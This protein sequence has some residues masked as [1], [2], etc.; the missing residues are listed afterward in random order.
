MTARRGWSL[1]EHLALDALVAFVDG[2]LSPSAWDRAAAHL[3]RCSACSAE[4]AAQRQARAAVRGADTPHVPAELLRALESIPDETALPT[5]P[6]ELAVT[7]DG[8][9]VTAQ[10]E[11]RSRKSGSHKAG[12][13]NA[14]PHI[15]AGSHKAGSHK[16]GAHREAGSEAGSHDP[17]PGK[18]GAGAASGA[19]ETATTGAR[20]E[21]PPARGEY[22]G[23]RRA[24]QGAGIMVSGLVLGALAFMNIPSGDDLQAPDRPGPLPL[25]GG[26]ASNNAGSNAV[27]PASVVPHPPLFGATSPVPPPPSSPA[28]PPA[29]L[30]GAQPPP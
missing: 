6:D 22:G 7:A 16:A 17:G 1:P 4:A 25:P 26:G 3:A 5:Q 21:A 13:Q 11:E 23:H 9:L 12:S 28:P 14:D 19:R 15:K 2:E 29:M 27:L 18:A 10:R 8:Q 20:E 30:V 24:R